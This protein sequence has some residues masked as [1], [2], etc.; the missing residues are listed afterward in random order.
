MMMKQLPRKLPIALFLVSFSVLSG[1]GFAKGKVDIC[2]IPP[3][4]PGNAHTISISESAL[5]AHLAHG[6]TLG[7][8]PDEIAGS[9]VGNLF[10]I[11]DDR[12]GEMGRK[13]TMSLVGRVVS[14][15][16]ACD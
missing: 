7:P 9:G 13:V 4:N 8:C 2:H 5:P 16:V 6:D 3:G 14:Q 12:E 15:R 10:T 11:C 1:N